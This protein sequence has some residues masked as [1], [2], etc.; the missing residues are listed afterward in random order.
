MPKPSSQQEDV[1][2]EF[3]NIKK[4]QDEDIKQLMCDMSQYPDG[5]C[6]A[7]SSQMLSALQRAKEMFERKQFVDYSATD[8]GQ[9]E[10]LIMAADRAR[11]PMANDVGMRDY[12][13]ETKALLFSAGA[14]AEEE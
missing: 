7:H 6:D 9:A 1:P 8:E 2:K 14:T 3:K 11:K 10:L 4:K 13:P 5:E 12:T